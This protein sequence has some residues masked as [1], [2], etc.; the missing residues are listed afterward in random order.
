MRH[1]LVTND[2]PPK[3]GGIQSYLW[4]LWRRL[5][6]EDVVVLTAPQSGA[7]VFDR[8]QPFRVVRARQPVLLPSPLVTRHIGRL[9]A[10]ADIGVVVLDPALPLGLVGPSLDR[11]YA[12]ILHGAEIAVP[13]RLPAGRQLL[14][15]VV[16]GA[17]LV[18]AAGS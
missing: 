2:F 14:A 12:V 15:R 4:E 8:V 3:V 5:P 1:L 10:E 11:P 17:A 9:V 18:V 7:S 16:S 6:P 13:G